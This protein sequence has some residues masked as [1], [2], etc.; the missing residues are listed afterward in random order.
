MYQCILESYGSLISAVKR[1]EPSV[2][3]ILQQNLNLNLNMIM[4]K[5]QRGSNECY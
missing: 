5:L 2:K 3:Q 4:M 1:L